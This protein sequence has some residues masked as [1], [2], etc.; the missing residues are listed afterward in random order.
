MTAGNLHRIYGD[1]LIGEVID[2]PPMGAWAGGPATIVEIIPDPDA[3]EIVFQ[4]EQ[5]KSPE[6]GD[7]GRL[8]IGVFNFEEV[9]WLR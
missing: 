5:M 6:A 9:T 1:A 2:T 4:V 3:D 7:F 8:T